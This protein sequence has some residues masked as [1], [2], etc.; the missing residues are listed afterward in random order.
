MGNFIPAR[1][2]KGAILT[3][4]IIE[5]TALLLSFRAARH[6]QNHLGA[7]DVSRR[8][9]REGLIDCVPVETALRELPVIL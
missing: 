6:R 8:C 9:L 2:K 3:Y 7:P 4:T 1:L 5:T